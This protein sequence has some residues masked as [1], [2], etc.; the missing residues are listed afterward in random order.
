MKGNIGIGTKPTEKLLTIT[1]SKKDF[2][3]EYT[4]HGRIGVYIGAIIGL[5]KLELH[6]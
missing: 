1:Y 4:L 5:I 2:K 6:D 3:R